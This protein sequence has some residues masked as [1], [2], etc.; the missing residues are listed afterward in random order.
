MLIYAFSY[1]STVEE[2]FC[3]SSKKY[4][5]CE[6][7]LLKLFSLCSKC[8]GIT[9]ITTYENGSMLTV[10][11]VCSS[12][13]HDFTWNSQPLIDNIP[14]GNLSISASILFSGNTPL[15][16]MRFLSHLNC[17]AISTTTFYEHQHQ[18][19]FPTIKSVWVNH[20]TNL[21]TELADKE[22]RL[23]GDGKCKFSYCKL[24]CL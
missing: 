18:Y 6:E 8:G 9:D 16:I 22:L 19:L 3:V 5:V 13:F 10:R 17:K 7:Q 11:Q 4:L 24:V 1:A 20:Q 23:T 2:G 12:C 14:A 15:P 21:H